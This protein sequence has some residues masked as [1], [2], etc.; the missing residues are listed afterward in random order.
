M[1]FYFFPLPL[2]SAGH[3]GT[4]HFLRA[5]QRA[6][7]R[8]HECAARRARSRLLYLKYVKFISMCLCEW[9]DASMLY[10]FTHECAARRARSRFTLPRV[11]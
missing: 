1:V 3:C 4:G 7:R 6:H 8:L 11:C 10:I 5:L 2:A 9:V